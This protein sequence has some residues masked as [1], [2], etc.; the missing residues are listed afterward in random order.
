MIILSPTP[1]DPAAL[2][3]RFAAGL[4]GAGAIATFTGLVRRE[5][6]LNVE[7]LDLD[8]APGITED[9]I[10]GAVDEALGRWALLDIL[11]AHRIGR[12]AVGDAVVFVATAAGHRRAAFQSCDF[13]MDF[14]KTDA[15]FWKKQISRS[16]DQWIE[17]R[18]EDYTDRS[19]WR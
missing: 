12:V 17:P 4:G 10:K 8:H 2:G 16:G 5:G 7:A 6:D 9:A 19:R 15:P 13:L 11:I 3:A 18:A 1:I 14:L